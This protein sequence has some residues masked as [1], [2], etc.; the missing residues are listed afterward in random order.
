M[1]H[2]SDVFFHRSLKACS[3]LI[4]AKLSVGENKSKHAMVTETKTPR[5]TRGP[6]FT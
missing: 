4:A 2:P 1:P 3:A 5:I 6:F